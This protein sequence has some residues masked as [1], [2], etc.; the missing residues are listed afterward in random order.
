[1]RHLRRGL[2]F[3]RFLAHREDWNLGIVRQPAADVALNGLRRPVEWL[4]PAPGAAIY[5]DPGCVEL[6]DG[7]RQLFAEYLGY[8]AEHGE[9]WTAT[10]PPGADPSQA[11]LQPLLRMPNHMSYPFPFLGD[12][13]TVLMTAETWQ[14]GE[15]RLWRY[16]SGAWTDAGVLF[17]DQGVVDPTLWRGADGWWLFC[18]LYGDRPNEH[19]HVFHAPRLGDPWTPH[20]MNP[21]VC[22]PRH[23]RPAGPLFNAGGLLI[24]PAQDCSTTYGAAVTVRAI[25]HL[26]LDRYEEETIRRIAPPAGRYPHGLHTLCPAGDVTIIDGKRLRV[27]PRGVPAR[28]KAW[29][30]R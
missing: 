4:P 18:T 23:A 10:I 7:S 20:R 22:D 9:I 3:V 8:G 25:R 21:V 30:G 16:R 1:M 15:A 28:L 13:G 29:L 14:A 2:N 24:R 11:R 27:D 5:A 17:P 12:D 26:S 6:A 19:L